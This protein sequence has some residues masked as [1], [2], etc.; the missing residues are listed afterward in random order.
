MWVNHEKTE[1]PQLI[2]FQ[3]L[4]PQNEL[5]A[6][7]LHISEYK[8]KFSR[9][10]TV[11]SKLRLLHIMKNQSSQCI[12]FYRL[13]FARLSFGVSLGVGLVSASFWFS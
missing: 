1:N 10:R 3:A 13:V 11:P 5:I 7:K 12:N 2:I 8:D 9:F 4:C 6:H